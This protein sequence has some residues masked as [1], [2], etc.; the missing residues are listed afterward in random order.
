MMRPGTRVG[1]RWSLLS[2]SARARY[3][4]HQP[5]SGHEYSLI[6]LRSGGDT[7]HLDTRAFAEE[8]QI[9]HRARRKVL[10]TSEPARDGLPSGQL[11]VNRLDRFQR[12]E[13]RGH[14]LVA[15]IFGAYH[16]LVKLIEHIQLGDHQA[17]ESI[18]H[19]CVA[20]QRRVE[21]AAAAGTPG[22]RSEFVAR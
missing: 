20:Q 5:R 19:G 14:G 10:M 3:Q 21:P 6:P 12:S 1:G 17:A 2:S 18:D 13:S 7:A 8:T 22:H 16:D 11:L 15:A 4:V 9:V